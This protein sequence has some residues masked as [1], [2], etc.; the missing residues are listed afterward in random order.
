MNSVTTRTNQSTANFAYHLRVGVSGHRNLPDSKAVR[1]SV[2]KAFEIIDHLLQPQTLTPLSW[3]IISSLAK[4]ADRIAAQVALQRTLARLEVI[5]P[6]HW[7]NIVAI[8]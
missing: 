7:M 3:T 6:L 2:I 1:A 8:L 5:T 4:G